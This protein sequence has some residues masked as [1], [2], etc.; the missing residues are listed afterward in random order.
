MDLVHIQG[1]IKSWDWPKARLLVTED[2]RLVFALSNIE[3]HEVS[4]AEQNYFQN[5]KRQLSRF[6]YTINYQASQSRSTYF[7]HV[8]NNRLQ[9]KT[10]DKLGCILPFLFR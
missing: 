1:H 7:T 2:K 5:L 10:T 3:L 4:T 8:N 9:T 6:K